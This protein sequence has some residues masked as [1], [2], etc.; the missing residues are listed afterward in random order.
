MSSFPVLKN[1]PIDQWKVTEL[2][3]ELKKRKLPVKGLKEELVRRLFESIQSEEASDESAE[4][5]GADEAVD[6]GPKDVE[7][8]PPADKD[9]KMDEPVDQAPEEHTAS[10]KTT[11]YQETVVD[12]TQEITLP[13]QAPEV[14]QEVMASSVED[15]SKDNLV[16]SHESLST[17][18]PAE[19][20]DEPEPVAGENSAMQEE[21][22][23]TV[24]VA[25]KTP[26]VVATNETIVAA[27][28]TSADLKSGS[29]QVNSDATEASKAVPTPVDAQIP[30]ADPMD[31][32]VAAAS[33]NNDVDLGNSTTANNEQ[34]KDS[35]L[36]N[37]DSK[38]IVSESNNQ[39]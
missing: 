39:N 25:E 5:A 38:P 15:S 3:D 37:E 4:D 13:P 24:L 30:D 27:D 33:V 20:G 36:M 22:P 23:D 11:A 19:K 16:A 9:V 29:S 1:K 17:E 10:Q 35:E 6:E 14:T 7:A 26:E 34:C 2:K 8:N 31:T 32:D 12:E 28:V 18:A 21:H